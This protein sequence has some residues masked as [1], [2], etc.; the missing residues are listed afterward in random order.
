MYSIR[1]LYMSIRLRG[2]LRSRELQIGKKP[3]YY[4][5]PPTGEL[6]VVCGCGKKGCRQYLKHGKK[7]VCTWSVKNDCEKVADSIDKQIQFWQ[8]MNMV[9]EHTVPLMDYRCD[10]LE[11]SDMAKN[12]K[13][14]LKM[15]KIIQGE[16]LQQISP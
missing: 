2:E 16:I 15:W 5:L 14:N 10:V 13:G 11:K 4:E 9:I 3:F 12:I 1:G 6:S 7:W 8:Y